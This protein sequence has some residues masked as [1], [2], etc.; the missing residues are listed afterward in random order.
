MGRILVTGARG[1][2]GR[3]LVP[4]LIADG[5][6]VHGLL[7]HGDGADIEGLT[8][9]H[10]GSLDDI[11]GLSKVVADIC[12]THVVHLAAV[13]FVAHGNVDEMYQTNLVG[14]QHLLQVLADAGLDLKAVLL[15]SSANIYGNQYE[16]VINEEFPPAPANDYGVSKLAME[17]VAKLYS[18]SLPIIVTRPFN[19]TGAGQSPSFII[20]KIVDHVRRA[21][22]HI[23]LGNL[24]VARDFS[25]VRV[26]ADC[27]ARMIGATDTI[28]K[29][30]NICS[31][32]AYSLQE[33]L[34]LVRRISGHEMEVR[35][36]PD[37]V[38]ANEVRF[39]CGDRSL[40]ERVIGPIE[41]PSLEDTLRWMLEA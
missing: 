25:D 16:G 11:E 18:G 29:T 6:E 32:R 22:P 13:A 14:T 27:Y 21:V 36:N 40:L 23:E 7:H 26:V 2:T 41:M 20:P 19:Y 38:R 30:F 5:H 17:H 8:A 24:H 35:I 3:Y 31:G 4:R 15:A 39:L 28:G 12:P 9:A 10:A 34:D 37:F 33:I 1:F